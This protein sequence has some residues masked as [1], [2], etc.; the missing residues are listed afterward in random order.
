MLVFFFFVNHAHDLRLPMHCSFGCQ[1]P[2]LLLQYGIITLMH[3]VGNKA[4]VVCEVKVFQLIREG[5]LNASS[6]ACHGL[7]YYLVNHQ[8]D[9]C[10]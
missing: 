1:S 4:D 2:L 7:L 5:P 9:D 6:P 8:Q 3:L 10:W